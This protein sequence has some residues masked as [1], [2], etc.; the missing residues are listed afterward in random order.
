MNSRVCVIAAVLC[1]AAAQWLAS[2]PLT[3]LR[4]DVVANGDVFGALQPGEFAGTLMLGGFR[5]VACDLMWMRAQKAQDAGRY[6]ESVAIAQA[7]RR[8]QPR[9][10]Q[11]WE[12]LAYNMAYN[13]AAETEDP[14]AKWAWFL[15]GAEFNIE[16]CLRNPNSDRL[17]RHLAWIFHHK[18]DDMKSRIAARSWKPL[19]DPVLAGVNRLLPADQRSAPLTEGMTQGNFRISERLYD[20]TLRLCAARGVHV[21]P[22]DRAMAVHAIEK[23]GNQ[24]RNRGQHLAALIRYLAALKRW[25]EVLAWARSTP[26]HDDDAEQ[27]RIHGGTAEHNQGRLRR[28]A[29]LLAEQLAEN[30]A[31]GAAAKQLM[32]GSRWDEAT[33]L[34]A[35]SGWRQTVA[36]VRVRWLDEP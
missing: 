28:K 18:G 17:L 15:A 11:I 9:F 5:G 36:Q 25:D 4:G 24:L 21:R 26:D 35:G 23:D 2:G 32:S 30:P 12:F 29:Q 31:T 19:L 16:G 8:M 27:R 13:I 33:T 14:E 20:A 7:I 1:F 3:R 6:Y 22:I 34:L 10:E